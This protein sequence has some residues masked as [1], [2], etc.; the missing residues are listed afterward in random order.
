[1]LAQTPPMGWNSWNTFGSNINEQLIFEI[2]DAM[3]DKGYRD[4]GYEYLVIDDCWSCRERDRSGKLVADP[5]KFPH[6]M[7]YVADYVHSK[8][9]K[10]GMYSAAG[11]MTCAGYPGSYGHEYQDAHT[12]AEWGVDYLKY[13][14]CHYPGSG[15]VRNSYLTMSMALRSTGREILF[16]GCTCGTYDP[17]DWMRSIGAHMY[18]S[19]ADITDE[20]EAFRYIAQTQLP[21]FKYSGPGCFNDMDMLVVG[22][23]GEGNVSHTDRDR[24]L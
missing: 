4:A 13:D 14:L 6:G 10:F 1:M 5:E 24:L 20:Y 18:R 15:D 17:W 23:G 3:V 22:M 19:H 2:A 9:L 7:K 11:I 16:A 12:F 8:G 21:N